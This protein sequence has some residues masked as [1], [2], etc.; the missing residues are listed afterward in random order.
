MIRPHRP[1]RATII[2]GMICGL[3]FAPVSF[4][5]GYI[6]SWSNA[7]C[8]TVWLF[9]TGYAF[10]LIRLS[11][12]SFQVV[13][14]PLMLLFTAIF[15]VKSV[16]SFILFALALISW[17]RSGIC[18]KKPI[19]IRLI[20]EIL[21]IFTG[22]ILATAFTPGSPSGWALGVW[23][24]FLVQALYFVLIEPA[25]TAEEYKTDMDPFEKASRRA[26]AILANVVLR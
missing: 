22:V 26:E 9:L 17:I 11:G 15:A 1:I 16:S 3:S 8:L 7:L 12:K 4:A 23:M 5:L 18:F 2:F 19:G 6:T 20:M 10:L 13:V 25:G 14:F 21:L 24:Y